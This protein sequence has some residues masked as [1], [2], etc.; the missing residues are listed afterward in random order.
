MARPKAQDQRDTKREILDAA[1]EL[2]AATGFHG[3]SM[4]DI[5]RAAGV[6]ES[7]IYHY[8]ASKEALLDAVIFEQGADQRPLVGPPALPRFEGD[9]SEL[10]DFLVRMLI[11]V[12]ARF[13]TLRERKRFRI[14]LSDGQR[15]ADQGK[16][17]FFARAV[18]VRRPAIDFF[19]DLL[20]RKLIRGPSAEMVAMQFV[21]PMLAWRIIM[22]TSNLEGDGFD[23]IGY[24]Q[25]HVHRFLHGCLAPPGAAP[26]AAQS[27]ERST[28]DGPESEDP[29]GAS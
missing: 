24:I 2:F 27:N 6:R 28:S 10:E 3:T 26:G 17:D 13:E 5:A 15:L 22:A 1:L 18:A 8:F 4:R 20:E 11:Q 29:C 25:A 7:G 12:S 16:V 14:L 21:A 9:A 19:A 23:R